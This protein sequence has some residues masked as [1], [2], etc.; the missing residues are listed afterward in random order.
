[1]GLLKRKWDNVTEAIAAWMNGTPEATLAQRFDLQDAQ[2]AAAQARNSRL[3]R[4][5][6]GL[7]V[8]TAVTMLTFVAA[9]ALVKSNA[10]KNPTRLTLATAEQQASSDYRKARA[11]CQQ[12]SSTAREACIA[13]AHAAEQRSRAVALMGGSKQKGYVSQLRAQTDAAIDAGD[14]D[15]IIV[16][17]ACNLVARGQGTL[18]EI[19]N[20]P[21]AVGTNLIPASMNAAQYAAAFPLKSRMQRYVPMQSSMQTPRPAE[22][23]AALQASSPEPDRYFQLAWSSRQ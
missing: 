7:L 1:M 23:V 22:R 21:N 13:E 15:A 17:P 18:C 19:Q 20:K 16:E 12:L 9:A 5:F 2:Q 8:F 14:R 10:G 11:R 6:A 4:F 3:A